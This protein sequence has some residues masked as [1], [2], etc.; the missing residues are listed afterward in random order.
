MPNT[1]SLLL[2]MSIAVIGAGQIGSAFASQLAQAGHYV[3]VVARPESRR[4]H[5]LQAAGGI[6]FQDGRH[7]SVGIAD[8]LDEEFAYDLVIVTTKAFQVDALLPTLARSRAAEL[9]FLFANFNPDRIRSAL[10]NRKCSF[11]MPFIQAWLDDHGRMTTR[12]T[13]RQKTLHSDHRWVD[14]FNGAGLP[15]AFEDDMTGW[16][17]WH[18]PMTIAIESVCVAGERRGGGA[19]WRE[20]RTMALGMRAG[21]QII[22]SLGYEMHSSAKS[23]ARMPV[24]IASLILWAMSRMKNFRELLA[25]GENEACAL[26][27]ELVA[28]AKAKPELQT[29]IDALLAMRPR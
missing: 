4:F 18:A 22:S 29:E 7:V 15:S 11:G 8:S 16:L 10:K 17:R 13:S 21:F 23:L 25:S 9:H 26:V 5:Q 1:A 3:T 2:P 14:L 6:A 27:D 28:A 24:T 12:I 20:A 19:T